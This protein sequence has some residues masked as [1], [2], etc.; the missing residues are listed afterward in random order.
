MR[1]K[2]LHGKV[3]RKYIEVLFGTK[4]VNLSHISNPYTI[5]FRIVLCFR[6]AQNIGFQNCAMISIYMGIQEDFCP[7]DTFL[8]TPA[9]GNTGSVISDCSI[10][11]FETPKNGIYGGEVI[12]T[13]SQSSMEACQNLWYQHDSFLCILY[14]SCNIYHQNIHD[15][16]DCLKVNGP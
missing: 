16:C 2:F 4:C 14:V 9:R 15:N 12:S 3:R 6:S 7:S 10:C 8:T 5:F 1:P 11:N 13:T